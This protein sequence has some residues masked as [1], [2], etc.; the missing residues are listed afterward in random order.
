MLLCSLLSCASGGGRLPAWVDS[1]ESVYPD[2]DWLCAVSSGGDKETAES[3]ALAALVRIFRQDVQ[4]DMQASQRFAATT[5]TV[6]ENRDFAQQVATVS[7]INS[8]MGVKF[9][10]ARAK[11]GSYYAIARIN[12]KDGAA[13]YSKLIVENERL[14]KS[15]MTDGQ[16]RSGFD[17]YQMLSF[18]ADAAAVTDD[19][20]NILNMLDTS[21]NGK[22]GD[23]GTAPSVRA[24]AVAVAQSI[25]IEVRIS[26]DIDGRIGMAFSEV[27]SDRGFKTVANDANAPWHLTGNF[28]IE[29]LDGNPNKYARYVVSASLKDS[30]GKEV[31]AYT[32]N[33]REGHTSVA[34]ARSRALMTAEK[35]IA[36]NFNQK[37]NDYLSSLNKA[38]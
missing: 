15:L 3:N 38:K 26:G 14:I 37:F 12:R 2:R 13:Q 22:R 29:D 20:I 17:A 21:R 36:Q 28:Q 16:K 19:C 32:E 23:Y 6:T 34:Q 24:L 11:D 18:A 8:L 35:H 31:L 7:N 4:V 33:A 5:S 25:V 27:L 10:S 30:S 1:P 9:E